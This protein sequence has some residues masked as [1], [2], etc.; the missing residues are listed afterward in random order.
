MDSMKARVPGGLGIVECY[1]FVGNNCKLKTT[2]RREGP[3]LGGFN[4]HL[5]L[6]GLDSFATVPGF[7]G[8]INVRLVAVG[9]CTG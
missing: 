7:Q 5:S 3:N 9:V 8:S 2:W 4:F 6:F 1:C